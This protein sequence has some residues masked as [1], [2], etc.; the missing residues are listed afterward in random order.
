[1]YETVV[2]DA[3]TR[4]V[5]VF[6]PTAFDNSFVLLTDPEWQQTTGVDTL[7]DLAAHVNAGKTDFT[8][9]VGED[10]FTR[11]DGWNGLTDHYGFKSDQLAALETNLAVVSTGLTYELFRR[12]EATL[13]MGFRTDPQIPMLGLEPLE[14]DRDFFPPYNAVPLAFEPTVE[15]V[16]GMESSLDRLGPAVGGLERI[17][18]LNR[19]IVVEDASPRT[20]AREFL[21]SRGLV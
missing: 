8:V 16:A 10:F 9:A 3:A 4:S 17:R 21:E 18:A 13:L 6:R 20:V 5:R 15:G 2:A 14:D 19:R 11:T 12:G 7:S 1:V